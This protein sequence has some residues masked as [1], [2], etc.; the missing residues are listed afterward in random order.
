MKYIKNFKKYIKEYMYNPNV[1]LYTIEL[2]II[3]IWY[4]CYLYSNL[5]L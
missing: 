4:L 5:S 2:S 3:I 1:W